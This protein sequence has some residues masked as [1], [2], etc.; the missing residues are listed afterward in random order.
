M[1]RKKNDEIQQRLKSWRRRLQDP[2]LIPRFRAEHKLGNT[3]KETTHTK[4]HQQQQ[5]DEEGGTGLAFPLLHIPWSLRVDSSAGAPAVKFPRQDHLTIRQTQNENFC[6]ECLHQGVACARE[7]KLKE[8]SFHYQ[9]GLD[10]MPQHV[11]LLVSMGAL[12]ANQQKY[13]QALNHLQKAVALDPQHGNAADYLAQVR[14]AANGPT[15]KT[16]KYLSARQDVLMEQSLLSQ[17]GGVGATV[18]SSSRGGTMAAASA[19]VGSATAQYDLLPEHSE[20]GEESSRKRKRRK[21]QKEKKK[22]KRRRRRRRR[23]DE[24][25]D[26]S[27]DTDSS[28]SSYDSS[29]EDD[30]RKRKKRRCHKRSKK[31]RRSEDASLSSSGTV[32]SLQL[33]DK[34]LKHDAP[35]SDEKNRG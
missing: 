27:D 18:K 35:Q 31:K 4:H 8:A 15:M 2:S 19:T 17:G 20:E 5:C 30:R 21:K 32:D 28:L 23:R 6:Q 14:A 22:H 10:L 24:D 16:T 26:S 12:L 1:E 11:D 9:Q 7:G 3:D 29:S 33:V 34:K 13:D 25:S